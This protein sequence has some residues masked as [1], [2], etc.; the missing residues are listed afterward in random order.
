MKKLKKKS[1]VGWAKS[2]CCGR[3]DF[4]NSPLEKHH[5][6]YSKPLEVVWLCK[7]CHTFIEQCWDDREKWLKDRQM[8]KIEIMNAIANVIHT[9][10]V[11]KIATAIHAEQERRYK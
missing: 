2:E 8:S 1:L 9:D 6:D 4:V 7:K 5:F 11:N 3:E 10:D